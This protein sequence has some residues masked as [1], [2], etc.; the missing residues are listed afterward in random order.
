MSVLSDSVQPHRQQPT[1]LPHP[2]DSPGKSTGGGAISFSNAWKW[3]VKVKSLCHVWL[4]ATPWT[5]AYEAPP[6]MGLSR[7]EYWSGMPLPSPKLLSNTDFQRRVN[8]KIG[9]HTFSS[10]H[11]AWMK[12]K[13]PDFTRKQCSINESLDLTLLQEV[14]ECFSP[15]GKGY[16]LLKTIYSPVLSFLPSP[17]HTFISLLMTSTES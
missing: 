14:G 17:N 9:E 2:W 8:C 5:V 12:A 10:L 11:T 16:S 7:Q 3:K 4:L 6:S 15:Q 13:D 1:R